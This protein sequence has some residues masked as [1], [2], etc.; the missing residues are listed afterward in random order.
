MAHHTIHTF[1]VYSL[2]VFSKF[3]E[4]SNHCH[5]FRALPSPQRSHSPFPAP[6]PQATSNVLPVSMDLPVLDVSHQWDCTLCGL[7]GWA[8]STLFLRLI[9]VVAD[10]STFFLFM[11][12]S[13]LCGCNLLNHFSDPGHLGC[14]HHL[15]LMKQL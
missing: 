13:P 8:F 9:H 10:V 2:G 3:I 1:K 5:N 14:S 12:Q 11:A 6:H 15:A 7:L 4:L